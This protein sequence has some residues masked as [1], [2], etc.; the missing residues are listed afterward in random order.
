MARTTGSPPSCWYSDCTL[1]AVLPF[2]RKLN[3]ALF[4]VFGNPVA[5]SLSPQIHSAF[6]AQHGLQVRYTPSLTSPAQFRRAVSAFFLNGGAGANVTVP[7]KQQ[8][9]SLV[10]H[11]TE[12]AAKAEAVNTLI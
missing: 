5:H 8:A 4:T 7:F 9:F 3:M 10:T 2:L 6:A 11:L 12:R 1:L